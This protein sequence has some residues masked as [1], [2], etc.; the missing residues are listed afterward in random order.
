MMEQVLSSILYFIYQMIFRE[1]TQFIYT[2][3]I[4]LNLANR[5]QSQ[6][7][8]KKQKNQSKQD[9]TGDIKIGVKFEI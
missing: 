4:I 8:K 5:F 6:F 1:N 3:L 7:F 9:I 2:Y